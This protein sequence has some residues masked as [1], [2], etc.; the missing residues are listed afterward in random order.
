MM[1][2]IKGLKNFIFGF[3]VCL[4]LVGLVIPTVAASMS[5]NATLVYNNIKI[6]FDGKQINPKDADGNT[7][8]PFIINGTTYLPVRAVSDSLGLNV[9][10]NSQTKTVVLSTPGAAK[11]GEYSRTDPAPL[12][13]TQK[14]N[15]D[16]YLNTYT[17]AITIT[18]LL[19]GD[20][21][22]KKIEEANLYNDEPGAGKEYILVKI[23][24]TASDVKGDKA[25]SLSSSSFDIYTSDNTEYTDTG[26]PVVPAP[27]FYGNI[28]DGATLEGYAAYLVNTNDKAPKAVFGVNYNGTGGIWFALY[29]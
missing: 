11:S 14:I 29:K 27:E 20:A 25:V 6:T 17:A 2:K 15:I 18:E 28:Y 4:L 7:V 26:W 23:K 10:W 16:D 24:C 3:V 9:D 1:G 21:A 8:E 13:T 19:R 12:G 22:W 5:V